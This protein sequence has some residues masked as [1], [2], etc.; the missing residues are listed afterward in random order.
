MARVMIH[1][2]KV[3]LK[4]WAE[5][6]NTACYVINRVTIRTGI[7]KTCYELWKGKKSTVKYFHI[8]ESPCYILRDLEYQEK[9]DPK[10]D[11]GVFLGYSSNSRAYRVH[12]KR[13]GVILESVNVIIKDVLTEEPETSKEDDDITARP[14]QH[15]ALPNLEVPEVVPDEESKQHTNDNEQ[16]DDKTN[17]ESPPA[18]S[19]VLQPSKTIE[20]NHPIT[21]EGMMT[22]GKHVNFRELAGFTYFLSTVEPK[23]IKEA[24]NDEYWVVAMQEELGNITRNKARLVAQGYTQIEGMGFDETF[25]PVAR[26]EAIRLP[27]TLDCH[28]KFKLFLMDVKSAF[29]NGL[30]SKEVYVAQPTGFDDPHHPDHVYRLK[31]ALYGLKQAPRA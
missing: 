20:K 1:A 7:E 19:W 22:Q 8:F 31:K 15:V 17:L 10:S 14:E 23:N 24:M 4:L 11:E 12:N 3:P 18:S 5:A 26:L 9:L 28:L 27:L 6:M 21:A 25:A 2:K 29:L 16:T 13:T 30:L